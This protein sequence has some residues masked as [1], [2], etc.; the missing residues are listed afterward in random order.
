MKFFSY[1]AAS[2]LMAASGGLLGNCYETVYSHL[3][4]RH[5]DPR[6]LG[7]EE[8]Y[9]TGDLFIGFQVCDDWLILLNPRGH[10][11]N[12]GR[13]ASNIGLGTRFSFCDWVFG[14]NAYYD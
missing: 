10:F 2:L 11:F 8:G 7:Y 13:F 6:G 5:R 1:Y 4:F 14:A 12:N 3:D 9:T